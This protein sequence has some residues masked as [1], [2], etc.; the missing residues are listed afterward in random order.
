MNLIHLLH[1]SYPTHLLLF[2]IEMLQRN[3]SIESID[4]P[5]AF[6]PKFNRPLARLQKGRK[7]PDKVSF[8][9]LAFFHLLVVLRILAFIFN[10]FEVK[11]LVLCSIFHLFE[12]IILISPNCTCMMV[13]CSLSYN[14]LL[15]FQTY[16]TLCL[17]VS[18]TDR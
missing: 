5:N 14:L 11:E 2:G 3:L 16:S 1:M 17:L 8:V 15:N 4:S 6:F 7:I 13:P 18:S 12:F 9:M 10:T